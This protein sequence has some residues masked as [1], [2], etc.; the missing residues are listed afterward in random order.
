MLF[1]VLGILVCIPLKPYLA[2]VERLARAGIF[3][4]TNV[5]AIVWILTTSLNVEQ[6]RNIDSR[7]HSMPDRI[8]EQINE[9]L[10]DLKQ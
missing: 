5:W 10:S 7:M 3:S 8:I 4:H 9:E 2:H 1:L 6:A